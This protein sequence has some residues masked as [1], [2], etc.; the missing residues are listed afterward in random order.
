M[1]ACNYHLQPYT[2]GMG[3]TLMPT[4][5]QVFLTSNAKNLEKIKIPKIKQMKCKA[6]KR[7]LPR[8]NSAGNDHSYASWS[9]K[10]GFSKTLSSPSYEE[11]EWYF[12]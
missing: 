10:Q 1:H 11:N 12:L 6:W 5:M 9:S 8:T 4:H 7:C 2:Q 3:D